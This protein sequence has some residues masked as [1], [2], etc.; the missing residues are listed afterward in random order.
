MRLKEFSRVIT[1]NKSRTGLANCFEVKTRG[2]PKSGFP[3]VEEIAKPAEPVNGKVNGAF[4][5]A[6]IDRFACLC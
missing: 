6:A 5:C 4:S 2:L 3:F 1:Q